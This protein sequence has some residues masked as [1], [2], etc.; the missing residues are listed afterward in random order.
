MISILGFYWARKSWT[1]VG[2]AV[3]FAHYLFVGSCLT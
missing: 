3:L 1:F 2:E